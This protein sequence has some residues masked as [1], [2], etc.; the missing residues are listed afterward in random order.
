MRA[1]PA[2]EKIPQAHGTLSH[3]V[4]G[5]DIDAGG[6]P[7]SVRL[8]DTSGNAEL[9]RQSLDAVARSS[10]A[11]GARTG[12]TYP[13]YRRQAEPLKAPDAP[14]SASFRPEGSTCPEEL[15]KWASI[16]RL[17]FPPEFLRRGIEGW[18]AIRYDLA[19][20][21][22]SG[23]VAVLAAE[24]AEAF[25]T[26]ARGIVSQGRRAPSSGYSG[27]VTLVRFVLPPRGTAPPPNGASND[28]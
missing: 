15:G 6:K 16:P 4:V 10:F 18:A 27:C 12:C 26:Q 5:F 24:P 19:P 22:A 21:G 2:F 11:P 7:R 9:D 23:N 3:S 13:Y 25:G 17:E 14:P 1:F 28:Q 8:V 20:W